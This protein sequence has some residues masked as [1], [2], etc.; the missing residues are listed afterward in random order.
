VHAKQLPNACFQDGTVVTNGAV[1]NADPYAHFSYFYQDW[2]MSWPNSNRT[3]A[4]VS[5]SYDVYT[6]VL[7]GWDAL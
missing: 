3:L 6:G 2:L 4:H 5:W 1:S 7:A